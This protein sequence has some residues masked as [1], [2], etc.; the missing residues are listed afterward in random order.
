MENKNWKNLSVIQTIKSNMG[1]LAGLVILCVVLSF[2][3]SSFATVT[4]LFN[5]VRQITINLFLAC[6]MT[7]VI[8]LAG[9]DLSVGSVIAV[10]GCISAGLI[11]WN[12]LPVYVGILGGILAGVVIG[13]INGYIVSSTKYSGIYRYSCNDEYRSWYCPCFIQRLRQFLFL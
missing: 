2:T 11:S 8:L 13:L 10:S 7:F 6:G 3:T 1:I 4:N 5:V 9:I 12:G